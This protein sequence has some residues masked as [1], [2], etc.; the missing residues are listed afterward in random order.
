MPSCHITLSAA[1]VR[2]IESESTATAPVSCITGHL[3]I[4]H[5]ARASELDYARNTRM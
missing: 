1:S 2:D 3:L 4:S 5:G